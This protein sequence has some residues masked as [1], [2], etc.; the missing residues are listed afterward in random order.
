MVTMPSEKDF[1]SDM[2][3][4]KNGE[5]IGDYCNKLFAGTPEVSTENRMRVLR[6]L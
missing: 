2:V 1:K 5:T 6:L 3:V 4:G